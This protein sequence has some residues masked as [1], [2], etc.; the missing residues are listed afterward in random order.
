[1]DICH[2]FPSFS[3]AISQESRGQDVLGLTLMETYLSRFFA[4]P[5][6][7]FYKKFYTFL[8]EAEMGPVCWIYSV[9]VDFINNRTIAIGRDDKQLTPF[10]R[11]VRLSD[12]TDIFD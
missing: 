2:R 8:A 4:E 5:A 10:L 11:T 7:K 6:P 3:K 12:S 9:L 1:M